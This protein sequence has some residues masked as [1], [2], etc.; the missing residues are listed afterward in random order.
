[1]SDLPPGLEKFGARLEQAAQRDIAERRGA[2]R[3]RRRLRD[4]GLP[5]GAALTA[6]A[7]SAGAVHL[8]DRQGAPITPE[9]GS[10]TAYQAAKDPAV[11]EATATANPSGGPPW[12][13]RAYTGPSGRECIQVGRLRD[14]VFGQVQPDGFRRLPASAQGACASPTARGPLVTVVR[15]PSMNVTLVFG[16][17]VDRTPVSIRY[18]AQHRRVRPA[19]FGAFLA[20]FDGARLRQ[21]VVIR[22]RVAGR[23][24]VQTRP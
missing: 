8:V 6:A 12:V 9:R 22:S 1:M 2:S 11:I 5:L 18:G 13:V 3:G 15:R 19:G 14:G 23:L 16:L 20:V 4:I 24:D 10:G 7:V 17:A 21:P